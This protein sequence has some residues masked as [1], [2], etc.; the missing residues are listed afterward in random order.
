MVHA[1]KTLCDLG[2]LKS[3]FMNAFTILRLM[4]YQFALF[5]ETV[6]LQLED[7]LQKLYFLNNFIKNKIFFTVFLR[8]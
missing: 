3:I 8:G 6:N 4:L 1:L 5:R 2:F 7:Y